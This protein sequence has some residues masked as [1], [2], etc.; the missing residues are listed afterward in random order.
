LPWK[1]AAAATKPS[2]SVFS[3][4]ALGALLPYTTAAGEPQP[5]APTN[6]HAAGVEASLS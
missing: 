5:P 1:L 3:M 4:D 6:H 2:L